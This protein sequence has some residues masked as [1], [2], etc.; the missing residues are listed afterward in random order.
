MKKAYFISGLGADERLFKKQLEAGLPIIPIPW[1]IPFKDESIES[2]AQRIAKEIP[3]GESVI[4]GGVS[5]GGIVAVE[6][7]KYVQV[8]KLILISSI[9]S[10]KELPWTIKI[11]KYMPVYKLTTAWIIQK[12]G[13][14][15][16]FIFGNMD[17]QEKELFSDMFMHT[18]PAFIK[19]SIPQIINWKNE[20]QEKNFIHIHGTAD[21]IFPIGLI[22]EPVI[23]IKGGSHV[24]VFTNRRINEILKEE[25]K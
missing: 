25:L 10:Y 15:A 1:K 23:K 21:L 3:E 18:T 19:W 2:Y 6:M 12:L 5:F 7:S 9:K 20:Y 16:R 14:T 4:L 24:M 11:W 17:K 8:E 13:L 22:N